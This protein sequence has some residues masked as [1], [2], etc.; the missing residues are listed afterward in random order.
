MD[1]V[2]GRMPQQI[3]RTY[4]RRPS[5]GKIDQVIVHLN[6]VV[7]LDKLGVFGADCKYQVQLRTPFIT[8]LWILIDECSIVLADLLAPNYWKITMNASQVVVQKSIRKWLWWHGQEVHFTKPWGNI[9]FD[10]IA[11]IAGSCERHEIQGPKSLAVCD[12]RRIGIAV[13]RVK[14]LRFEPLHP[15]EI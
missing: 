15:T 10:I 13:V 1:L 5:T 2:H 8:Q 11:M 12:R 7:V 6:S 14:M 4:S 9:N 3:T